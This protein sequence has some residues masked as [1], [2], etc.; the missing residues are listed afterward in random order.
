MKFDGKRSGI[1]PRSRRPAGKKDGKKAP[2]E[3]LQ[4]H[5]KPSK[6]TIIR[7]GKDVELLE[8]LRRIL[9]DVYGISQYNTDAEIYRDLPR[10]Y[11]DAVKQSTDHAARCEVLT[12]ERD[13][14]QQLKDHICR[15][16]E[17]CKKEDD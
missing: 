1:S 15:I 4:Q 8:Q 5:K 2:R 7:D 12:A 14:L 3:G 16:L 10:L 17:L 11:L 13:Q 9:K 6:Y